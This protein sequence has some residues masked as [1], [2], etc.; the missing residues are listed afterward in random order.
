MIE[1]PNSCRISHLEIVKEDPDDLQNPI[2]ELSAKY[3]Y[4]VTDD[5]HN[6]FSVH[7]K[8][9]TPKELIIRYYTYIW[10]HNKKYFWCVDNHQFDNTR[11]PISSSIQFLIRYMRDNSY[12]LFEFCDRIALQIHLARIGAKTEWIET[13]LD[14]E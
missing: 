11:A 14:Q 12:S 10:D 3:D 2:I 9:T 5:G 13:V 4:L 7:K 1:K 8:V 6:G